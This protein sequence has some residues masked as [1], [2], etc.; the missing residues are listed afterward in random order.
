MALDLSQPKRIQNGG[1]RKRERNRKFVLWTI[2]IAVCSRYD[3]LKDVKY[4][5]S[6]KAVYFSTDETTLQDG[7][8]FYPGST[9][10]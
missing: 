2:I 3:R 7:C 4:C 10:F 9:H 6:A 5:S 1:R 8:G